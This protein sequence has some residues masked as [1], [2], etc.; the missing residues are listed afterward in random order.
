MLVR[1]AGLATPDSNTLWKALDRYDVMQLYM[2][3]P[4][5][6]KSPM[7]MNYKENEH[8]RVTFP[9]VIYVPE[10]ILIGLCF[11]DTAELHQKYPHMTLLLRRRDAS[12]LAY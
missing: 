7:Y 5:Y 4:A 11:S 12:S 1:T 2:A 8:T 10:R 3:N 9:A 6:L